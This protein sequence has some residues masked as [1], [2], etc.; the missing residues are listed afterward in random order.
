[1]MWLAENQVYV[2]QGVILVLLLMFAVVANNCGYWQGKYEASSRDEGWED[3]AKWWRR[4]WRD[5]VDNALDRN[6]DDKQDDCP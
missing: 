6:E 5:H 3:E 4:R 2:Y 1:M